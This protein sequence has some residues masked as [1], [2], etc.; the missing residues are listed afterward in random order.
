MRF[1]KIFYLFL[2]NFGKYFININNN[3][4][5]LMHFLNFKLLY[6]VELTLFLD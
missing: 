3:Y 6:Q 4:T 5:K 1:K 2:L